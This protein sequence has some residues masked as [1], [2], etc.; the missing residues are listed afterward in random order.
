MKHQSKQD[1]A[2]HARIWEQG[3][4][5]RAQPEPVWAA[6]RRRLQRLAEI[7]DAH[8]GPLRL[9][10]ELECFPGHERRGMRQDKSPL[11]VAY[12]D[13]VLRAEGLEGD[14]IGE[15]V[16][17]FHMSMTEAHSLFCGCGYFG[18]DEQPGSL[19]KMAASRTR[20]MAAKRTFAERW[21][22]AR[23]WFARLSA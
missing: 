22:S 1:I 17:F 18:L 19:A 13:P 9:F 15:A 20:S 6:R 12:A 7:L 16:D 4:E 10:L 11:S 2:Q 23:G 3:P 14:T 21:D 5:L 8:T